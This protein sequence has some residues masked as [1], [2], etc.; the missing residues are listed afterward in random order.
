MKNL[1]LSAI[2]NK[3]APEFG[4]PRLHVLYT[5]DITLGK[6]TQA[7]ITVPEV[8]RWANSLP[9]EACA[10]IDF[11]PTD[12]EPDSYSFNL[13]RGLD[14]VRNSCDRMS[15]LIKAVKSAR[16]DLILGTL[17]CPFAYSQW[18]TKEK[19]WA[20]NSV[21][22]SHMTAMPDVLDFDMYRA[23]PDRVIN[24]QLLGHDEWWERSLIRGI[25]TAKL[26]GIPVRVWMSPARHLW[27]KPDGSLDF[28]SLTQFRS[29]LMRVAS[30]IDP[31]KGDRIVIWLSRVKPGPTPNTSV[32]R[33][34]DAAWDWHHALKGVAEEC[35]A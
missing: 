20:K 23:A 11:E 10:N 22:V 7:S 1:F 6:R 28:L 2:E 9:Q 3:G 8:V 12:A 25:A 4:C 14:V 17:Y 19:L 18:D 31:G 5:W 26:L 24:G 32:P 15:N 27:T 30:A 21:V 35:G 16:P 33:E 13:K 29:D 34:W